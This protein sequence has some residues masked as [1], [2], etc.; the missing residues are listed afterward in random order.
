MVSTVNVPIYINIPILRYYTLFQDGCILVDDQDIRHIKQDSLR[1]SIGVVPQ[2]TV[3]FNDV[4]Y[5]NIRYGRNDS[6]EDEVVKAAEYAD[7]HK[8]ILEFPKKYDT[9]V[10]ERGLK[11]SGGEK[12]RVAIARTILKDPAIILLDEATSALDT[13]TERNIQGS[14]MRVC[15]G[16]STIIVAHR[17]STII[18]ANQIL[19]LKEGEVVERG[20]HEELLSMGGVYSAMWSQQQQSLQEEQMGEGR[21][22]EER[23]TNI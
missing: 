12:Q 11:L 13:Q 4:I 2:D 17:L 18:H 23:E 5:Y 22:L 21:G 3:L 9:V 14:L 15:E 7:I 20:K 8:R 1:H 6:S 19:V 16:R 10:G